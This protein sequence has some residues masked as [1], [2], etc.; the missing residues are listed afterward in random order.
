MHRELALDPEAHKLV[1]CSNRPP[2]AFWEELGTQLQEV[3]KLFRS[4]PHCLVYGVMDFHII[5][6]KMIGL[7][8]LLELGVRVQ[9]VCCPTLPVLFT[10]FHFSALPFF[11]SNGHGVQ[12]S[13]GGLVSRSFFPSLPLLVL[14]VLEV[15]QKLEHLH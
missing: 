15:T 4:V 2:P 6:D 10:A 8:A 7:I 13:L 3:V 5:S 1:L 9:K 12:S 14:K 11:V